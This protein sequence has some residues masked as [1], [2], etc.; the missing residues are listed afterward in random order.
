M[1][2]DGLT[3]KELTVL[4]IWWRCFQNLLDHKEKDIGK[5]LS[6]CMSDAEFVNT[7]KVMSSK[8]KEA[9]FQEFFIKSP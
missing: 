9:L 3:P 7:Q 1:N 4:E 2:F 5:L 8:L 6:N